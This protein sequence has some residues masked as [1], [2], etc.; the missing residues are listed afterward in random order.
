MPKETIELLIEGG[1]A[2]A[3]PEMGQKLGPMGVNIADILAKI[4][5]KTS[6][7]KG[8]KVPV[9]LIVDT[10]TKEF[11]I[12]IGTP[13]V[14]QLIKKELNLEKGSSTPKSETVGNIA[15][16][17][18]IKI[19]KMKQESMLATNFKA[20]VLS[21][22]GTCDSL[23]ILIEGKT[24]K[25]ISKEIKQGKYD[26]EINE[27]KTEVDKEKQKKLKEKLQETQ[28]K[29]EQEKKEE[30]EKA[31]EEEAAKEEK[32]KEETAGEEPVAGEEPQKP[33]EEKPEEKTEEKEEPKK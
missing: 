33:E 19:A 5:E 7:F 6:S 3:G 23:G 25:E 21:V 17:Q 1:K 2:T 31:K 26:K 32:A 16:E 12:S 24:S 14:S 27:E 9:K 30:E 15:I 22:I 11:D 10:E 28:G 4:N 18:T 29:E 20:V 8:M 13:P